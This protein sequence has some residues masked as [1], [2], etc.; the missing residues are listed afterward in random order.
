MRSLKVADITTLSNNEKQAIILLKER[1]EQNFKLVKLIMFGSKARGDHNEHSDVDLMVL[2]EDPKTTEIREKLSELQFD[3]I[4]EQDAPL[5]STIENYK[6]WLEEKDISL[7]FKD[8]IESE[9][10]EIEI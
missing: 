1:L 5:M 6:N 10:V 9:G 8:N 2:V 7:P 4:M 3:V